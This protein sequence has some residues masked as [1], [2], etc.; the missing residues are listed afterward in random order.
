MKSD[1]RL[2]LHDIVRTVAS[3]HQERIPPS[4]G[5]PDRPVVRSAQQKHEFV[6][7]HH[8]RH[9]I[10]YLTYISEMKLAT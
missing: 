7:M 2:G 9:H 10:S 8:L 4:L 1:S 6:Y 3:V 5:F